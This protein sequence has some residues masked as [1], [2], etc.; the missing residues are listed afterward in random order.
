VIDSLQQQ[1]LKVG[2]CPGVSQTSSVS[3]C[4]QFNGFCCFNGIRSQNSLSRNI[5][6]F[7]DVIHVVVDCTEGF[8][9]ATVSK[10]I[11]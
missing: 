11:G 1:Y 4:V 8:A 5:C 10:W 3:V 7:L 6:V 2:S 9:T